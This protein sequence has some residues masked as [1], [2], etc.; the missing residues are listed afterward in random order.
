MKNLLLSLLVLVFAGSLFAEKVNVSKA[1]AIAKNAYFQKINTY[2]GTVEMNQLIMSEPIAISQNGETV[3]YAFNFNGYGTIFI[4]AEDAIEPVIGYTF[5]SQYSEAYAPKNF[6]GLLNEYAN[7]I[8]YLR[9]G[10]IEASPEISIQWN[11]LTSFKPETFIP[12]KD[13]KDLEP[14]LTATWNQDWPYN[15]LCPYDDAGP[16][17]HVYVGCVATAMSQIMHFWRYPHQGTGSHTYNHYL[18]GSL[19]ANFGTTNYNWDEMLDNSDSYVNEAMALIGFHAGVSVDMDYGADGSG[20]YSADVPNALRNYFNYDNSVSYKMR[21][22]YQLSA[23]KNL[24][25]MELDDMCPVYYSG[26]EPGVGGHAFVL[27]GVHTGDD[28]YHFN[29]GWSGQMNGWFLITNAGGFTS[30]Q[31]MVINIFPGDAAYPYGCT[32]NYELTS[33]VGSFEDGSGPME[34]YDINASCSWLINPQTAQ[35]S[36]SYIKLDCITLDTETGD[37][38]TVYD[39]ST[40]DAEVLATWSGG[41]VP[42]S[43][44]ST[45][46]Q[47][48]ITFDAN[49]NSTAGNGFKLQYKAYQPSY[50]N[51]LITFTEPIGTFNDGSGS[52]WYKS[53]TNCMWK[54][55]PAYA[56][57]LTL[58][59]TEFDTQ[60]GFDIVK[61]YDASNNQVIGQYSGNTI[62]DPIYI[63]S[64]KAFITFQSNGF[65]NYPGWTADWEIG[66][67]KVNEANYGFNQFMAYPNPVEDVLTISLNMKSS[68]YLK[69][70]LMNVTGE[71]VYSENKQEV[72]GSFMSQIST[73][74]LSS[75][76]YFLRLTTGLG[77][78]TEKIVVK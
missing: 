33:L 27:D 44:Y 11:A 46:N 30:Q 42:A 17:D 25:A 52:F 64:G 22:N 37:V 32:P 7:H 67:V 14:M 34:T 71:V 59:F 35:D 78:K 60:E 15:Y 41:A 47:M 3:I 63:A 21:S 1:E 36:V 57:D 6:K 40:T 13:A 18:Y 55:E 54:I 73:T 45:G 23:W 16:G 29:F 50:C 10:N 62:P 5:D 72:L 12:Q 39:G 51:G 70:E 75:G 2:V 9:G 8:E 58:T 31:G 56:T 20:A 48:L 4:A 69:I 24:V 53:N 76:I 66:N 77:T 65:E 43:L 74:D 38:I 26:Q 61:V 28:M 68:Q 19:T 49:G